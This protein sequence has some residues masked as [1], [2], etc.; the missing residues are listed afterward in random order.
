M[1][2]NKNEEFCLLGYNATLC[3]PPAFTL[4]SFSAYYST[5]KT[6]MICQMTVLF[7]TSAVRTSNPTRRMKLLK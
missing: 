1:R 3:L 5:L 6:E 7:T 2:C 4:A